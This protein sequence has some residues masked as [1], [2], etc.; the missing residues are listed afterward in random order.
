MSEINYYLILDLDFD[1]P[2]E[3]DELIRQRIAE[4]TG[5]WIEGKYDI[6]KREYRD[7]L[8]D[9]DHLKYV[10]SDTKRR[11]KVAKDAK[12]LIDQP[13]ADMIRLFSRGGYTRFTQNTVSCIAKQVSRKLRNTGNY[14]TVKDDYVKKIIRE[15]GIDIAED[16]E[17]EIDYDLILKKYLTKP[18]GTE[19]FDKKLTFSG[20]FDGYEQYNTSSHYRHVVDAAGRAGGKDPERP[21]EERHDGYREPAADRLPPVPDVR[22]AGYRGGIPGA[23]PDY[24]QT[25][26]YLLR[27]LP[28]RHRPGTQGLR[29]EDPAAAEGAAGGGGLPVYLRLPLLRRPGG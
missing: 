21:A 27:Q 5:E 19:K 25:D 23:Q 1:P 29:H 14:Y 7:Y 12:K 17:P 26:N 16:D 4:K 24:G 3:D 22:T 11:R 6:K 13:L 15:N 28:R 2:V 18:E 10:M 9:L 20:G 8:D